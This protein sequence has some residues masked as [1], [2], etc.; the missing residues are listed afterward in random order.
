MAQFS[1]GVNTSEHLHKFDDLVLSC[2]E[3]HSEHFVRTVSQTQSQV[4]TNGLRGG[5]QWCVPD[6]LFHEAQRLL[7]DLG[8][9]VGGPGRQRQQIRVVLKDA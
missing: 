1:V 6:R 8:T 2:E 7:N 3:Q 4:V 9:G 5:Q